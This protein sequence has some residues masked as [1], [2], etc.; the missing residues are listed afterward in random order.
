MSLYV[1]NFF[2]NRKYAQNELYPLF[3]VNEFNPVVQLFIVAISGVQH[4]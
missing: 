3:K 2:M 1:R 4:N